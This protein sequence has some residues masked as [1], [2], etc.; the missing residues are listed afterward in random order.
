MQLAEYLTCNKKQQCKFVLADTAYGYKEIHLLIFQMTY[1]KEHKR[2]KSCK[3][4]E[5]AKLKDQLDFTVG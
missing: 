2:L 1:R 3:N 5:A 4:M